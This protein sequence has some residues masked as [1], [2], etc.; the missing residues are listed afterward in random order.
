M[1]FP[2][3][4]WKNNF[5]SEDEGSEDTW[6][7]LSSDEL[8]AQTQELLATVDKLPNFSM[9]NLENMKNEIVRR[10][11]LRQDQ[12]APQYESVEIDID[13]PYLESKTIDIAKQRPI[14]REEERGG[15]PGFFGA[16]KVTIEYQEYTEAQ[17]VYEEKTRKETRKEQVKLPKKSLEHYIEVVKKETMK[18]FKD[19]LAK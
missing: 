14:I 8:T 15:L 16:T 4:F 2:F 19:K 10:A 1:K 17:V 11:K 7:S 13:M 9:A 3:V 5:K 6:V 12:E 18:E